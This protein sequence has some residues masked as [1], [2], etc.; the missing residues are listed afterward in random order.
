MKEYIIVELSVRTDLTFQRQAATELVDDHRGLRQGLNDKEF[1]RRK[2]DGL[3]GVDIDVHNKRIE[4][5]QLTRKVVVVVWQLSLDGIVKN[6]NASRMDVHYRVW[7]EE[8]IATVI[9]AIGIHKENGFGRLAVSMANLENTTMCW[10][11]R[12]F[13][14]SLFSK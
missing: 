12:F 13:I 3:V 2:E 11:V 8:E 4:V 9:I 5:K 10:L 6:A 14:F 1:S 7:N